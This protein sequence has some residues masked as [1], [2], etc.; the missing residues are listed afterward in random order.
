[1]PSARCFRRHTRWPRVPPESTH[2]VALA[3]PP[4]PARERG[5]LGDGHGLAGGLRRGVLQPAVRLDAFRTGGARV[6]RAPAAG[7][8]DVRGDHLRR[9]DCHVFAGAAVVRQRRSHPGVVQPVWPGSVFCPGVG[10]HPGA[11]RR[12]RLVA[13]LAGAVAQRDLS[14]GD[15]LS[16]RPAQLRADRGRLDCQLLL[17]A[18]SGSGVLHPGGDG[19]TD[20]PVG[21][22][23]SDRLHELQPRQPAIPL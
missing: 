18:R 4:L 14:T 2:D 16:Q 6:C 21:A 7:Q 3:A 20:L 10:Q 17:E 12:R 15:R 23:W 11:G 8:T 13:A 1:M 22:R 5:R 9:S 19:R